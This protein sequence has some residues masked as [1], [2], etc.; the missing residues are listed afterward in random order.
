MQYLRITEFIPS[1]FHYFALHRPIEYLRGATVRDR[2][3]FLE[4]IIKFAVSEYFRQG[5]HKNAPAMF[6]HLSTV[7]TGYFRR[8][9]CGELLFPE[10][11]FALAYKFFITDA[12]SL[13]ATGSHSVLEKM[14]F[15]QKSLRQN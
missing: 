7:F 14:L 6:L 10:L 13:K 9:R 4:Y 8:S 5:R 15:V 2:N 12:L 11:P 3:D 1:T